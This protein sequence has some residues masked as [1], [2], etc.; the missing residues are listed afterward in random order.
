[1]ILILRVITICG[2]FN[3]FLC[4]AAE[5]ADEVYSILYLYVFV[6]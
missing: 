1:M 2:M 5:C 3:D 6:Q 4:L